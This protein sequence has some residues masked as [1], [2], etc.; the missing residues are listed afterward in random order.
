MALVLP[1]TARLFYFICVYA[2]YEPK[3]G[4]ISVLLK[5][6]P[7]KMSALFVCACTRI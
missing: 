1:N 2:N 7:H 3:H 5:F 4:E 6:H